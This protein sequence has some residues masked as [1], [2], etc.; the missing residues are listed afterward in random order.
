MLYTRTKGI[1]STYGIDCS[2][3][4]SKSPEFNYGP[5]DITRLRSEMK[6]LVERLSASWKALQ[7]DDISDEEAIE[8][9][10]YTAG[11]MTLPT[12][13]SGSG[14]QDDHDHGGINC[15]LGHSILHSEGVTRFSVQVKGDSMQTW[16][17]VKDLRALDEAKLV[18]YVAKNRSLRKRDEFQWIDMESI[19]HNKVGATKEKKQC[20]ITIS[21]SIDEQVPQPTPEI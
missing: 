8:V 14:E 18:E 7:A 2:E 6:V 12:S 3:L 16:K 13:K 20:A 19:L 5:G 17:R 15:I 11:N 1:I 9:Q 10:V 21:A 4:I